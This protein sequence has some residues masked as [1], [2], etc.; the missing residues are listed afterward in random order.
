M[1][2]STVGS[3]PGADETGDTKG[4]DMNKVI[5]EDVA[6]VLSIEQA[7]VLATALRNA[8][9]SAQ[10]DAT[11][12]PIIE[13]SLNAVTGEAVVYTAHGSF[14]ADTTVTDVRFGARLD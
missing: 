4:V 1:G 5:T 3:P 7:Y 6:L 2:G 14:E 13:V 10:F 11:D 8:A 9:D 12:W